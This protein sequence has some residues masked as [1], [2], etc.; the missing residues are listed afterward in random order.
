MCRRRDPRCRTL[1][2]TCSEPARTRM[3][4][5]EK[6]VIRRRDTAPTGPLFPGNHPPPPSAPNQA[7]L[8]MPA[9]GQVA[10]QGLHRAGSV[11]DEAR[12]GWRVRNRRLTSESEGS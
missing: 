10:G 12:S 7:H 3:A 8:P 6:Y 11:L 2:C 5:T 9:L 4:E 1:L